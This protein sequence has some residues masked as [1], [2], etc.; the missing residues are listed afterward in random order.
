[1]ALISSTTFTGC[2]K[3]IFMTKVD[4]NELVM[5]EEA[6]LEQNVCYA[7]DGAYFGQTYDA[8]NNFSSQ[9][10]ANISSNSGRLYYYGEDK[11]KIPTLYKNEHLAIA[12]SNATLRTSVME[13]FEDVGYTLGIQGG[14]IDEN[15]YF[16][17]D[18]R[19]ALVEGSDMAAQIS[20]EVKA[21]TIRI[22][23][24]NGK[25]VTP[26]ML[27][28]GGIIA[29]LEQDGLYEIT[30]YAGTY[31]QT[32]TVKADTGMLRSYE[33]YS[34]NEPEFTNNNY[35]KIEM[36]DEM[37]SGYYR[38][39]GYGLFKYV[40]V[41]KKDYTEDIDMNE[42]FYA[43]NEEQLEA[44]AKKYVVNIPETKNNM[45]IEV[46][47]EEEAASA[48]NI[49][50]IL[51]SP[52]GTKYNM[53]L[54]ENV[55]SVEISEMIPGNWYVSVLPKNLEVIAITPVAT[56]PDSDTLTDE[57]TFNFEEAASNVVFTTN[58]TGPDNIWGVVMNEETGDSQSFVLNEKEKKLTAT[59][60][61]LQSGTYVA[62]I[63]HYAETMVD[64]VKY[65]ISGNEQEVELTLIEEN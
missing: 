37:K 51:S 17:Y 26:E 45:R 49:T 57:Y 10:I 48:T 2:S 58:Y 6:E 15:G 9:I 29:G 55:A 18:V 52:D 19:K 35:F 21:D 53:T 64:E 28:N 27:G 1:M 44:F 54:E 38:L 63:Y 46:E 16:Y 5:V 12:T 42:P 62:K 59:F 8:N 47:F 33:A 23:A 20:K 31:K 32:L 24:I 60:T 40:A 22:Y 7:K 41:D 25:Q 30:F 36:G 13:R 39:D 4:P 43:N 3:Q 14:V 34:A 56:T 65:D 50:C 61:Y 11:N